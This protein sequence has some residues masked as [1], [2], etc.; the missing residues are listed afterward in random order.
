M[1]Q[2]TKKIAELEQLIA[3]R[4]LSAEE[5]EKQIIRFKEAGMQEM[6]MQ[7]SISRLV[8]CCPWCAERGTCGF[9]RFLAGT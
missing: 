7:T 1:T 8:L 4:A 5:I 3:R 6:S 2:M 9:C